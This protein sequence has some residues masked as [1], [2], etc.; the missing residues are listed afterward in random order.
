M[1]SVYFSDRN[2]VSDVTPWRNIAKAFESL[3]AARNLFYILSLRIRFVFCLSLAVASAKP[4]TAGRDV[5]IFSYI[6]RGLGGRQPWNQAPISDVPFHSLLPRNSRFILLPAIFWFYLEIRSG[7]WHRAG[8]F[9]KSLD[10]TSLC[11]IEVLL[12]IQKRAIVQ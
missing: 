3:G 11:Q 9:R 5:E 8:G 7:R 1:N 6:F 12:F 10:M 2:E 4:W